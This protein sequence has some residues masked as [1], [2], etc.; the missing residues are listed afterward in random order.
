MRSP[1]SLIAASVRVAA[2]LIEI[3]SRP[4][5]SAIA[6]NW[7]AQSSIAP[8]WCRLIDIIPAATDAL[9]VAPVDATVRAAN[10]LG[11]VAPW[12][13]DET[14]IAS[15]KRA[16]AVDGKSPVKIKYTAAPNDTRP[17]RS[18]MSYPRTATLLG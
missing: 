2:S 16:R 9:N 1:V 4:A 11:G 10:A 3:D 7:R 14:K 17:M 5:R 12:S 13:I 8:P 15:I 18:A 6:L